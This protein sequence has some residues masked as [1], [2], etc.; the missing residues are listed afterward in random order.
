MA[1][2]FSSGIR[3]ATALLFIAA[4]PASAGEAPLLTAYDGKYPHDVR[5]PHFLTHPLVTQAVERAVS[6]VEVRQRLL[7]PDGPRTPIWIAD[8]RIH[9][10][11]CEAH[12]C[13]AHNWMISM[14]LDG[15]APEICYHKAS[16]PDAGARWYREGESEVRDYQCPAEKPRSRE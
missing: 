14:G 15:S 7:A 16:S 13:G 5:V 4:F 3:I 8:G 11:G 10:W 1:P 12:L 6:D 2:D 9:S